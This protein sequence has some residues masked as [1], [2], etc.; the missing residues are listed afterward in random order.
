LIA[1]LMITAA[2]V[3]AHAAGVL[4]SITGT[5]LGLLGSA[6][7]GASG[8]VGLFKPASATNQH[9]GADVPVVHG[10]HADTPDTPQGGMSSAAPGEASGPQAPTPAQPASPPIA[11]IRIGED[12]PVLN[13]PVQSM[14]ALRVKGV[15]LQQTDYSCG[16]AAVATVLKQHFGREVDEAEVIRGMLQFADPEVVRT[17]GFSLL[18]MRRYVDSIGLRGRG[19]KVGVGRLFDLKVP[20]ITLIDRNGYRHFVII[21]R[22]A[23]GRVYVADPSYGHRTYRLE[24]F[25]DMWS[26]VLLAIT[27]PNADP[28]SILVKG[29]DTPVLARRIDTLNMQIREASLDFG[30]RSLDLF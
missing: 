27:G 23:N 5:T 4:D 14:K 24:D 16:A 1:A 8:L 29:I 6:A 21:K 18:D 25:V 11:E 9:A 17:S 15:F 13:K 10:S 26:G 3:G 2:P 7:R 28:N 19:F 20:A 30:L 22:A 12:G